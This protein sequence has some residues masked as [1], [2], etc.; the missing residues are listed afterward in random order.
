ME[1]EHHHHAPLGVRIGFEIT[2]I[3]LKAAMVAAAFCAI[4]ELHKV[5]RAIENRKS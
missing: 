1:H 2:K 5:H 4:K 3:G